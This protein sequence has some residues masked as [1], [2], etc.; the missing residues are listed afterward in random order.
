MTVPLLPVGPEAVAQVTRQAAERMAALVTADL[1]L[2]AVRIVWVMPCEDGPGPEEEDATEHLRA[3]VPEADPEALAALA[4][5]RHA[6]VRGGVLADRATAGVVRRA[7]PR[8]IYLRAD[9]DPAVAAAVV[10]HEA[11]HLAQLQRLREGELQ[12]QDG[13]LRQTLEEDA[14]RYAVEAFRRWGRQ[15]V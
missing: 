5:D 3:L 14:D 9:L 8:T 7:E 2:P 10:A 6:R 15:V 1:R 4:A 12:L 13:D 11:R